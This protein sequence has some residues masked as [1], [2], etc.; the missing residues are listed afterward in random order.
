MNFPLDEITSPKPDVS[1]PFKSMVRWQF[2]YRK[3]QGSWD[4]VQVIIG[5]G[6]MAGVT[7]A[8]PW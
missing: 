5:A 4:R 8:A 1:P 3:A 2:T 7:E 6:L